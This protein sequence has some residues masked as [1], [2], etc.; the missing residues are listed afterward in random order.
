[1]TAAHATIE[2]FTID[3]T[4]SRQI[5]RRGQSDSFDPS[6]SKGLEDKLMKLK[7]Q[8]QDL[9]QSIKV[10]LNMTYILDESDAAKLL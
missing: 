1:M 6:A 5:G 4:S 9:R 8:L 2:S 10:S 3:E 7:G